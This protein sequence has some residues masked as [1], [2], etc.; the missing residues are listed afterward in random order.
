MAWADDQWTL[1]RSV[2]FVGWSWDAALGDGGP[3]LIPSFD[4]TPTRF[5]RGFRAYLEKPFTAGEVQQG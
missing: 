4:G 2:S 5:G 1:R 3:S